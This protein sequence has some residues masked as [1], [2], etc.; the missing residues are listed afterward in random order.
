MLI[1]VGVLLLEPQGL[2]GVYQRIK[3]SEMGEKILSSLR[4]EE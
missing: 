2:S 4:R 1:L 3:R